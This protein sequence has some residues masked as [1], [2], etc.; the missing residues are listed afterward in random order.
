MSDR[1][2]T[3]SSTRSWIIS[4]IVI[5][6]LMFGGMGSWAYYARITGAVI[7]SGTVGVESRIKTVQ[8]LS[9]GIISQILVREGDSVISGELLLRLDETVI[10]ANLTVTSGE[11]LDYRAQKQRLI[12]ERDQTGSV[13]FGPELLNHPAS[14]NLQQILN[15][16]LALFAT[17]RN[18]LK[19]EHLL[20]EQ[21]AEQ[22]GQVINGLKAQHE[23]KTEQSGLITEEIDSLLPLLKKQLIPKTRILVLRREKARIR[24]EAGQLIAEIAKTRSTIRETGLRAL[25]SKVAFREKVLSELDQVQL[26]IIELQERYITLADQYKHL[27]IR[28]PQTG[29]IHKLSV[30]TL[31]GVVTPGMEIVQI[32]PDQDR[33][34]IEARVATNDIDQIYLNQNARIQFSAFDS[35]TTPQL[36]A[37]IIRISADRLIDKTT[38]TSYFAVDLALKTGQI[39]RLTG[40]VLVSGM[41]AD[42]FIRTVDRTVL[43]ILLKPLTDQLSRAFKAG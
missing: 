33:L 34:I 17:R 37:S 25:K 32:V 2:I 6:G 12:A 18:S 39:E 16:Q 36:D 21:Q 41:S 5:I 3:L 15:N 8:H 31:G 1:E 20:L 19:N 43:H 7:A 27:D 26:K 30:H 22:Y 38:G 13:N 10:R 9:G 11:L 14:D 40:N 24:G 4:G 35:R 42:V 23:A 29:R 28:A